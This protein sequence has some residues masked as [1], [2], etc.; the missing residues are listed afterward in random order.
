MS[1]S[2]VALLKVAILAIVLTVAAS[3][4]QA[5]PIFTGAY[6][7]VHDL[8]GQG[9]TSGGAFEA[10][11]AYTSVFDPFITFCLQTNEHVVPDGTTVYYVYGITGYAEDE[12]DEISGKDPLDARSAWIYR[13]YLNQDWAA[14][15]LVGAYWEQPDRRGNAVQSA[16]WCLEQEGRGCNPAV[17]PGTDIVQARAAELAPAGIGPTRVLNLVTTTKFETPDGVFYRPTEEKAQDL[18]GTPVPEPAS[19]LL[20]GTGLAGLAGMV[21]RRKK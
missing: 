11:P 18:L 14:L 10:K 7:T 8:P 9:S 1:R 3:P 6:L 15:G 5:M 20:F 12:P 21:R 17:S 16:I 19:M 2:F 13:M 4:S